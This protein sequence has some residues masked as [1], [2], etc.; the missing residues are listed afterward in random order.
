VT[1]STNDFSR[2]AKSVKNVQWWSKPNAA[3]NWS[4]IY[5]ADFHKI[6][7]PTIPLDT[8]TGG[9]FPDRWNR[10]QP[11]FVSKQQ[12]YL[13]Y[14]DKDTLSEKDLIIAENEGEILVKFKNPSQHKK[15]L[16]PPP[17]YLVAAS[18]TKDPHFGFG[19]EKANFE[20]QP[21]GSWS[22]ALLVPRLTFMAYIAKCVYEFK[23][24]KPVVIWLRAGQQIPKVYREECTHVRLK[25]QNMARPNI[26]SSTS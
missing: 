8:I 16:D 23:K 15:S 9:P 7:N 24:Y 25:R 5:K 12:V 10:A 14:I 19:K 26:S 20:L 11:V 2:G 1:W 13:H 18:K 4:H 22:A 21:D 17:F 6:W 3:F